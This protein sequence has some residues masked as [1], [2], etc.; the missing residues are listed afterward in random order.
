MT[1]TNRRRFLT[2]VGAGLAGLG[3]ATGTAA[4]GGS[5]E[6]LDA[7]SDYPRIST[8][9]HFEITWWGSVERA[10]GESSVS[11]DVEGD[12]SGYASAPELVVFVHG[13]KSDDDTDDGIDRAYTAGE[14]L[15][16]EGYDGFDVGFTW[17]SDKGGGIDQGW[18]EAQE[19]ANENGPKLAYFVYRWNRNGGAPVRL[20]CHSLGAQV[21]LSAL[22]TLRDWGR[23]DAVED[24]VLLGGAAD[25]EACAVD[26]EYG[27]GA[28]YAAGEVVN[29]HKEDDDVLRWAY[30]LGEFNRAVG[31]TGVEG[32]P[33]DNWT[34]VDVTDRVPD[35]YSY[36]ELAEDGGCFDVVV[37]SW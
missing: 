34:D 11:Y 20:V 7:P 27:P 24:A 23:A 16:D 13:W 36:P 32:T 31:E 12:W 17:D 8:R 18:Y 14:A 25:N 4:A 30:S 10:D 6:T 33:P 37:D 21:T 15:A 9:D 35:H 19:I 3:V 22:S 26:G 29:C 2:T 5:A 28:A 1:E